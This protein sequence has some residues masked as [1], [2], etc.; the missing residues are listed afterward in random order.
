MVELYAGEWARHYK[1]GPKIVQLI[2]FGERSQ[3]WLCA[4][5]EPE[6]GRELYKIEAPAYE[7]VPINEASNPILYLAL[8]TA[9][10]RAQRAK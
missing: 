4:V 9:R 1:N 2:E 8:A 7:L 5:I 6:T 3:E 10:D